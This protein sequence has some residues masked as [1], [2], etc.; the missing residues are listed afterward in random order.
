[1]IV[2]NTRQDE[3][4]QYEDRSLIKNFVDNWGE[5]YALINIDKLRYDII[6]YDMTIEW[7]GMGWDEGDAMRYVWAGWCSVEEGSRWNRKIDYI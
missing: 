1:L 3:T 2:N 6:W 4:R 5:A 7:N